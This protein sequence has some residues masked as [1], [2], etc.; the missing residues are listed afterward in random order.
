MHGFMRQSVD[1]V[2]FELCYGSPRLR[3]NSMTIYQGEVKTD[4]SGTADHSRW[5]TDDSDQGQPTQLRA[6]G[7]HNFSFKTVQN[8]QYPRTQLY[9]VCPSHQLDGLRNNPIFVF[10]SAFHLASYPKIL[11]ACPYWDE[12]AQPLVPLSQQ[13][14]LSLELLLLAVLAVLPLFLASN[15]VTSH[16]LPLVFNF[17]LPTNSSS[18]N[19]TSG[20]S[21]KRKANHAYIPGLQPK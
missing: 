17:N 8:I 18:P 16:P 15:A 19:S 4:V 14:P 3:T 21:S 12:E 11:H 5:C 7:L 10:H 2:I 1:T 13:P 20:Y 9:L 6:Q